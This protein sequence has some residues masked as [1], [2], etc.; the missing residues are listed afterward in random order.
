MSSS[1]CSATGASRPPV[2]LDHGPHGPWQ[3]VREFADSAE[4]V[5]KF[6]FTQPD[7][8][9]EAV[10]YRYP[11]YEERT[12]ICCSTM[13]GCPIGC[14]F[15]GT[16]EYFV[17]NLTA[18]EIASQPGYLLEHCLGGLDPARIGKLQIMVM[19]M[20]E[21]VLNKALW[22]AFR[23]LAARYPQA[24]LLVSTSAPDI[25][26]GWVFEMSRELPS[27]GLQFSVHES[28]D[29]AR[30][31]LIPFKRKLDL[32]GIARVGLQ[33]HEATG[34]RP[35]F[36]YCAH[37]DN[38]S[39][40]DAERLRSLFDPAVWEAT[41]SV[42]C[43]RNE[44]ETARNEHQRELA[45]SFSGELL[46]RGYNVRVFDPAGMD[47]I[48]G[49]CGQLWFVQDWMRQH[50]EHARPSVGHGHS[51][52]HAPRAPLASGWQPVLGPSRGAAPSA[53]CV[54]RAADPR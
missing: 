21:P 20:G 30:D 32:A 11:T 18:E 24:Q 50:P 3:A 35:F 26:W 12:V 16:G 13:S 39:A 47:T 37:D 53:S 4:H 8:A 42:I 54:P 1:S 10:L 6:V 40:A 7:C 45:V 49:G 29:A 33:W 46:S 25:D 9:V 36:N 22:E 14:R 17:R 44:F 31:A 52:R 43:E 23:L 5:S 38:V 48:G 51:V 19:S 41:V 2:G 27:V 34:R 15:C 28:T